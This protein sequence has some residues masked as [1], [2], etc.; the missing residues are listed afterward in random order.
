MATA[1]PTGPDRRPLRGLTLLEVLAAAMI[2]AMVMTVLIGT[3]S[4]AVHHVG[5]SAR[6][7]E[8]NLIADEVLAD[9]EI[10]MRQGIAPAVDEDESTRDLFTVR[11]T[12][13]SVGASGG[14]APEVAPA[15][16]LGAGDVASLL[17]SE[18]PEVAKHLQQYEIE[19]AWIEQ[20]G[21]QHVTRT[22]FAFDW[23]AASAEFA[24]LFQAAGGDLGSAFGGSGTSATGASGDAPSGGGSSRSSRNSRSRGSNRK[25]PILN[26][27]VPVRPG[28]NPNLPRR[29]YGRNRGGGS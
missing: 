21:P 3:S 5:V 13:T 2:F 27:G 28:E 26:E 17:G 6:R 12:R 20:S 16:S 10:Q 4:T 8:A 15:P 1:P 25:G 22:T 23:Q 7:L 29:L 14:A 24:E 18:L 9:L 19:V 11:V